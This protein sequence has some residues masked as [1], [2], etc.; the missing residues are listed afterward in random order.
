VEI[1]AAAAADILDPIESSRSV[2]AIIAM[3]IVTPTKA[4]AAFAGDFHAPGC[5]TGR[6]NCETGYPGA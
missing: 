1:Q 5:V 2:S 6:S 3:L 4:E